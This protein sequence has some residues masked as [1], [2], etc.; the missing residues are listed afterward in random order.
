MRSIKNLLNLDTIPSVKVRTERC[1][2]NTHKISHEWLIALAHEMDSDF[3][4]ASANS[5]EKLN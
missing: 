5:E 3:D 1:L 2:S 4:E